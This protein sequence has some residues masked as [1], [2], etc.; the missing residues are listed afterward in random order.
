[1]RGTRVL[2]TAARVGADCSDS[3][4]GGGWGIGCPGVRGVGRQVL[5]NHLSKPFGK[6]EVRPD[7][8][9]ALCRGQRRKSISSLRAV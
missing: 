6:V 3:C 4:C 5:L 2:D 1:M 9:E 7:G 8:E